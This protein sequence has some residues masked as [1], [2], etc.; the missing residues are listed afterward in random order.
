MGGKH[1]KTKKNKTFQEIGKRASNDTGGDFNHSNTIDS[2]N[3][4]NLTNEI[5]V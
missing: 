2:F 5:I 4:I 3:A 1:S